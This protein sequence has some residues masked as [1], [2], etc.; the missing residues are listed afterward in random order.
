MFGVRVVERKAVTLALLA[1]TPSVKLH[2]QPL[3][4]SFTCKLV[5]LAEMRQAALPVVVAHPVF[6]K[7]IQPF[8]IS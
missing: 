4:P 8:L 6:G 3:I 2:L 5:A 1:D 7:P